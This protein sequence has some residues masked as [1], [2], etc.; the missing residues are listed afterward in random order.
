MIGKRVFN[1][2][3]VH[4]TAVS[5]LDPVNKDLVSKAISNLPDEALEAINV[6]KIAMDASF[7]VG[8]NYKNFF[9]DPFPK[10]HESWN[11][12]MPKGRFSYRTFEESKIDPF[13][14]EKSYF[15]ILTILINY[16]SKKLQKK[17]KK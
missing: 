4:I 12:E 1:S 7:V 8:L 5:L 13:F 11:V 6:F 2:L 15:C 3:Y 9:T 10:L 16:N 14:T 17:L